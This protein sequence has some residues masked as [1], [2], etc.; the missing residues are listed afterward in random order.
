MLK[1]SEIDITLKNDNMKLFDYID[2]T[3]LDNQIYNGYISVSKHPVYDLYIYNYTKQCIFD[4]SWN[5]ATEKCRGLIVDGNYNIVARPFR[6]FY[7]YEE[8]PDE[9]VIPNTN[10]KVYD[11][12][13]G[14]LGIMY[15]WNDT[16]YIATRGSFESDQALHATEILHSKYKDLI[17]KLDRNVTYLFEIIYPEDLHVVSYNGLDDIIL[18]AAIET[19]TGKEYD[20]KDI[21]YFNHTKTYDGIK[22]WR[23][24]R[25]LFKYD[26]QEGYVVKFDNGYRLKLKYEE[27]FKLHFLMTGLSESKIFDYLKN[28]KIDDIKDAINLFDEEHKMIF[29]SYIEKYQNWYNDIYTLCEEEYRDDFETQKDAAMYFK[30]CTYPAVLFGMRNGKNVDKIIWRIIDKER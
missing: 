30:N 16:P 10:F 6:K 21:P 11:K 28:D 3:L 18:L 23:K 1:E 14:S 25:D 29:N 19:S 22:D 27:Y 20:L 12:L 5:E 7:N 15:W 24:M 17:D 4:K 13:D 8:L 9:S 2:K 26:G